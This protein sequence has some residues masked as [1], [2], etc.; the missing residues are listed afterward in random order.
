MR[1]MIAILVTFGL[2]VAAG[3]FA[4]DKKAIDKLDGKWLVVSVERD[5]KA[6]E[7]LKGAVRVNA[8]E[9]YT[10]TPKDGKAISGAFKVDPTKKPKTMDMMPSVLLLRRVADYEIRRG[11]EQPNRQQCGKRKPHG[12]LLLRVKWSTA[13]GAKQ[14]NFV[15][16]LHGFP[17]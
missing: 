17:S 12:S 7:G 8:G 14:A 4:Q 9:K 1:P 3:V 16:R 13:I 2:L 10:L 6:D 11:N 15:P 5:G